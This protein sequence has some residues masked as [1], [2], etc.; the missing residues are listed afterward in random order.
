MRMAALVSIAAI[1]QAAHS[2]LAHAT[3]DGTPPT[4]AA[5][6]PPEPALRAKE[7]R[8]N[9]YLE[10]TLLVGSTRT[11]GVARLHAAAGFRY[12]HCP[13]E[14]F[15]LHLGLFAQVGTEA[16]G[17]AFTKGIEA[18]YNVP[19]RS[20]RL[21]GRAYYGTANDGL[22][23]VGGGVR[24]RQGFVHLGF[25]MIY[26]GR[27]TEGQPAA[28]G[29]LFALGVNGKGGAIVVSVLGVLAVVALASFTT[30]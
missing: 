1:V 10:P 8:S 28:V 22:F 25:E 2:P 29:G 12:S 18:E 24:L 6:A 9:L 27:S 16:I 26:S 5:P 3:P 15:H 23:I 13:T 11:E 19:F 17:D 4:T 30:T 20:G 7:C 14:S 21:G